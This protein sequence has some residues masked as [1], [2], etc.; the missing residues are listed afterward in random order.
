MIPTL[1]LFESFP[2]AM[3][4]AD[5]AGNMILVNSQAE[6]L[7]GY[8]RDELVGQNIDMFVPAQVRMRHAGHRSTYAQNPTRRPMG[9][10]LE[11]VGVRK[12]GTEVPVEIS[13]IPIETAQGAVVVSVIRDITER[14]RFEHALQA[15][16][17]E[18]ASANM[19]KDQFLAGM[20]HELRTPLNA[21]IGFTGTL[22]MRLPGPLTVEQEQQLRIVQSSGRHLLS[23]ITDILDLAKI[24]AGKVDLHP[25][26]VNVHDVVE[27]V[28]EILRSMSVDKK[29]NFTLHLPDRPTV[30]TC[31]RRALSQILLNL[32]TNAIK[33]TEKGSVEIRVALHPVANDLQECCISIRDTGVGIGPDDRHRIF[34]AFEQLDPLSTR[35]VDG[36]GLGL[37]LSQKLA[38]LLG[39]TLEF[40]SEP[41]VGSTFTL[42]LPPER[43]SA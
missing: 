16:N 41:G 17:S 26:P 33:Y 21:I 18:L 24:G 1:P 22:L 27:E 42:T 8:T 35:R 2:D 32:S 5:D 12:D 29:L 11:L 19:A 25:E 36:V 3:I 15:T 37:H 40:A 34:Q 43:H 30:V 6:K 13:L 20:S 14:K 10:G 28:H 4:A 38:H 7:F 39:A 9:T 31:D 23:L